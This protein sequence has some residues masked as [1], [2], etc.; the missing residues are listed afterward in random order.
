MSR[1]RRVRP[2]VAIRRSVLVVTAGTLLL[3]GAPPLAAQQGDARRGGAVE[4]N[5]RLAPETA[6]RLRGITRR[7]EE[8]GVPAELLRRKVSEGVSKGVTG[9]RLERAIEEYARRL[10]EARRLAGRGAGGDVLVAAAEAAERGVSSGRIRA[11]LSA[12]PNP[13]RSVVGL[14]VLGELVEIGVPESEASRGVSA[15]LDRGLRGE[16]LLALSAAVRRRVGAGE[17]P[18]AALRAEVDPRRSPVESRRGAP[19]P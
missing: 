17:D 13:L 9:Q 2:G 11:F 12:N 19:G 16:R 15:A 6:E 3:F 10:T 1:R 5:G 4:F 14:R 18:V 8:G 7:A